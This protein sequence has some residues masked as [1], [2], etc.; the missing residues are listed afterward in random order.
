MRLR[1]VDAD[2]ERE[3]A[4]LAALALGPGAF[5]IDGGADAE[6]N[7]ASLLGESGARPP[8]EPADIAEA[9]LHFHDA[10]ATL[11]QQV[12]GRRRPDAAALLAAGLKSA[13]KFGRLPD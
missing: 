5:P 3:A 6:G 1:F 9:V 7:F 10:P 12:L 2:D 8:L 11:I 13:L 4:F